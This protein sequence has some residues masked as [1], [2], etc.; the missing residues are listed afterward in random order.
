MT[1]VGL[2]IL[3]VGFV[4]GAVSV[5]LAKREATNGATVAKRCAVLL[6]ALIV[7]VAV[8]YFIGR[9]SPVAFMWESGGWRFTQ[10]IRAG[11]PRYVG[12]LTEGG[13]PVSAKHGEIVETPLG[14][15]RYHIRKDQYGSGGWYPHD[16]GAKGIRRSD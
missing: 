6:I 3:F 8:G 12:E 15:Y 5:V 1:V 7:G 14:K 11:D 4:L 13:N 16:A 10:E 2:G 9:S